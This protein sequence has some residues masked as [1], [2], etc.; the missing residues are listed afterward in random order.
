[1][2]TLK[3]TQLTQCPGDLTA[4]RSVHHMMLNSL[5]IV[6]CNLKTHR[7]QNTQLVSVLPWFSLYPNE[8]LNVKPTFLWE[9]KLYFTK[10][11]WMP[12]MHLLWSFFYGWLW[13]YFDLNS[14]PGFSV[15][16]ICGQPTKNIQMFDSRY[17]QWAFAMEPILGMRGETKFKFKQVLF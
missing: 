7:R 8:I 13:I 14:D 4:L 16:W 3:L 2:F 5:D 17:E 9:T 1:M 11:N 12:G 6:K 10:S 15:D